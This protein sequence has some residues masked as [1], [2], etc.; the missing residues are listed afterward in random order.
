MSITEAELDNLST[1]ARITISPEEKEKML[2]DMQAI[3]GYISEIN[4]VEGEAIRG[5]E[6]I[7]NV[8]RE[9][10]VTHVPGSNTLALL[11]EAPA[12]KE[13]YVKVEQVLK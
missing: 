1:L 11:D 7:F 8:V 12:T 2:V 6:T 10:V 4:A 9:D 13:G 5:Q 3:L